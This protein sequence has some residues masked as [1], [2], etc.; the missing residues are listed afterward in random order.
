MK[1]TK[2]PF[3]HVVKY[4]TKEVWVRCDSAITAMG[5]SAMVN[6]FYPGYTP[7]IASEDYLNELRNQQVQF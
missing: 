7:H 3:D 5:I 4:D 1:K 6:Q 2:F